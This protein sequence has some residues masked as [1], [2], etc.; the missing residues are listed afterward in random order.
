[1]VVDLAVLA[2][3]KARVLWD[4]GWAAAFEQ[5]LR[6]WSGRLSSRLAVSARDARWF[7]ELHASKSMSTEASRNA[8][9]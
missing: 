6:S 1:M 3:V 4:G 8:S 9:C 7:K 5:R 2:L